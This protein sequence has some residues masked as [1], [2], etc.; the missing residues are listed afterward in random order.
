VNKK[1]RILVVDDEEDLLKM[2]SVLLTDENYTPI[3]AT[4]GEE[5]LYLLKEEKF[6]LILSDIRMEPVG[7]IELLKRAKKVDPDIPV[8]MMTAFGSV[9]NA[10]TAMKEGAFHYLIKP[11]KIDEL[12]LLINRALKHSEILHE[13]QALKSELEEKYHYKNMVGNSE[14]MQQIYRLIDKISNTQTTVLLTGESGTGK[15]LVAKALHYLS[16]SKDRPFVAVNCY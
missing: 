16:K 3:T 7:G 2:L 15:E 5:A 1:A 4:S 6:D 8:I 11:V 9:E 13:N 10:V 14:K 12:L